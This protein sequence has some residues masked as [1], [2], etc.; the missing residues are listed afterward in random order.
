MRAARCWLA[1][2]HRVVAGRQGPQGRG[3]HQ[4]AL[5]VALGLRPGGRQAPVEGLV[6][7]GA[8]ARLQEVHDLDLAPAVGLEHLEPALATTS[9]P[10]MGS[11]W[12]NTVSPSR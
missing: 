12:L 4:P 6:H 3:R 10:G 8:G 7:A 1:Q 5:G 2:G 11:S 9:S